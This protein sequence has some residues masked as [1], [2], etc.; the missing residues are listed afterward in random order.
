MDT[1]LVTL[2]CTINEIVKWLTSCPSQCGNHSGGDSV[3]VSILYMRSLSPLPTNCRY[4]FCEPD[5]KTRLTTV[6]KHRG[7]PRG[8][9]VLGSIPRSPSAV[10]STLP[11]RRSSPQTSSLSRSSSSSAAFCRLKRRLYSLELL[12]TLAPSRSVIF[13][14][15]TLDNIRIRTYRSCVKVLVKIE[16][17]QC[18]LVVVIVVVVVQN[19]FVKVRKI[20]ELIIWQCLKRQ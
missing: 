10:W 13:R 11:S 20:S 19:Y 9:D 4:H 7:R 2:P 16:I 6:Q 3:A 8:R 5:V 12:Q 18:L 15:H 17:L 1:C 14:L